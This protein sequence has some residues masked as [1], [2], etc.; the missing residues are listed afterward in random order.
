MNKLT[1]IE[2]DSIKELIY[3][4]IDKRGGFENLN[5]ELKLV[6]TKLQ[7]KSIPIE[8]DYVEIITN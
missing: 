8:S 6:L 2:I 1:E 7:K 3:S 4:E 5:D